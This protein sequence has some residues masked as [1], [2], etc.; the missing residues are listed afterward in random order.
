V[1]DVLSAEVLPGNFTITLEIFFHAWQFT[2]ILKCFDCHLDLI[3]TKG[4]CSKR[5][6]L[7]YCLRSTT[8]TTI[9]QNLSYLPS[10]R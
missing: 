6:I 9:P 3:P 5:Q 10:L 4:L 8:F 1:L 2:S 7:L